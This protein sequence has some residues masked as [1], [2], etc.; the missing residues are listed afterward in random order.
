MRLGGADFNNCCDASNGT[1]EWLSKRTHKGG[2]NRCRGSQKGAFE[3]DQ[4]VH[5]RGTLRISYLGKGQLLS[6]AP[7]EQGHAEQTLLKMA[8]A[9]E[10]EFAWERRTW[11]TLNSKRKNEN[12]RVG[13]HTPIVK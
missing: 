7:D 2:N 5:N 3:Y 9:S 11:R 8:S 10:R 13:S 1:F 4:A 6:G 12:R